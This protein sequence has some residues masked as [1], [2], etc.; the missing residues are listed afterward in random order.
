MNKHDGFSLI[1]LLI[2][3]LLIGIFAVGVTLAINPTG[4]SEKQLNAIGEKLFAQMLYAQ[5]EALVRDEA[6]GIVFNQSEFDLDIANDYEWRRY[7]FSDAQNTAQN[8][9]RLDENSRRW[10]QTSDPLGAQSIDEKFTWSIEVEDISVEE[11][12][13]SLLNE[14]NEPQPLIVFYPSGEIT[15]FA[16]TIVWSDESLK[17]DRDISDQR[18]RITVDE[19]GELLRFRVGELDDR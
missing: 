14:D 11:N 19:R 2:V 18:Y 10:L 13:D 15:E 6:A 5:D 17:V 4:S 12:L 3:M 16:L 9:Q 1:E 7:S 8:D